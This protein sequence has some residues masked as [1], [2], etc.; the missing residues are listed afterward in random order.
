MHTER[1][2]ARAISAF[3]GARDR[4]NCRESDSGRRFG[5]LGGVAGPTS[6]SRVEE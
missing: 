6:Q 4:M 2:P 1:L 5:G 3:K